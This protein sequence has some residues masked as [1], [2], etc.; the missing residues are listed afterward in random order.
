MLLG[1]AGLSVFDTE[2]PK[3]T[4]SNFTPTTIKYLQW[5]IKCQS[6]CLSVCDRVK[7]QAF[8]LSFL[9]L[10]SLLEKSIEINYYYSYGLVLTGRVCDTV[11][12][13]SHNNFRTN[14]MLLKHEQINIKIKYHLADQ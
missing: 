10:M 2:D 6:V 8:F 9:C 5:T 4:A 13:S 12:L 3:F 1:P 11:V 14:Q 7:I